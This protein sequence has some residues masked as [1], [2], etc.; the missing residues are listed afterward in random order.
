MIY[1]PKLYLKIIKHLEMLFNIPLS[2]FSKLISDIMNNL[3]KYENINSRTIRKVS[4]IYNQQDIN[5]SIKNKKETASQMAHS[6]NE[7]LL[8]NKIVKKG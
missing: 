3:F 5:K 6:M 7:N 2:T 1:R 8:Y 4:A